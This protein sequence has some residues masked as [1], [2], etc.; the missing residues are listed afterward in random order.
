M[1][2][3]CFKT[4][5]GQCPPKMTDVFLSSVR[6]VNGDKVPVLGKITVPLHLNGREYPC[7]FH[8]MQNLAFDAILGRNFLQENRALI[9]LERSRVTFKGTGY[10]GKQTSLLRD[11]VM[12]T[13]LSQ[14]PLKKDNEEKKVFTPIADLKTFEPQIVSQNQKYMHRGFQ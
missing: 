8:I 3:K 7:D 1:D 2:V 9:D 14:I 5:Y 12:G 13:F 11:E 4:V 6:T 10:L